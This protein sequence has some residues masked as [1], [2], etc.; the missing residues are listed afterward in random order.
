MKK[1]I[2]LATDA[3]S[4]KT[5][6]MTREC[7]TDQ[8]EV[9][10]S[11]GEKEILDKYLP[12]A[13][14]LI[15]FTKGIPAEMLA[16]AENCIYIQKYGAGYNNICVKEASLRNIPVG[17][18]AGANARSVAECALS[19]ILAVY[20]QT[21]RG[22]IGI[23]NGEWPKTA[24]RDNNHELTGKTVG[25]IGF[26]NIGRNLRALLTG[27][28][29]RVLYYD[30]FRPSPEQEKELDV[31]YRDVD[32]LIR[33][34]DVISLHCPLNDETRHLINDRTIALM[35]PEAI[36]INCARG[37]VV[38][39]DA[40]Y[41]ALSENRILGAGIDTFET[42]PLP[43]DSRLREL[44]NITFSPHN[45]GGTVEAVERVVRTGAANINSMLEKGTPANIR[46]IVN[47]TEIGL[48]E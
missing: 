12:K 38:D 5:E 2:V 31:E 17:N 36:L 40:L 23:Q 32:D 28:G 39:E 45:G 27:F 44:T 34:S 35:K 43:Q 13:S 48:G 29:C 47:R 37:S 26:G 46:D 24:L 10:F 4:S 25:I 7:I 21:C 8:A 3:L 9:I 11:N 15:S 18:T 14:V 16:A 42:E 6:K 19:L 20:R 22:H 1:T 30:A 33:E 41:H